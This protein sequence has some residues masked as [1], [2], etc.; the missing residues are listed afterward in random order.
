VSVT[1]TPPSGSTFAHGT[2]LVTCSATDAHQNAASGTFSVEVIDDTPPVITRV[3]ATPQVLWPAN[4]RL[5]EVRLTV[6][7]ADNADPSPQ[8]R[9]ISVLANE[10]IDAPGS[11]NTIDYDWQILEPLVVELRAER[12]GQSTDRIYTIVIECVDGSGNRSF[13]TVPVVVPHEQPGSGDGATQ[14]P[15]KRRS[16]RH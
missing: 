13:A 16:A 3:T 5:V 2:T 14:T 9:I 1:C 7:A 10:A 11:G 15:G 4:H 8:T 12:S 6:E